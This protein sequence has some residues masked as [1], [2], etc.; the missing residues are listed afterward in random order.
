MKFGGHKVRTVTTL[1]FLGK[2]ESR[3]GVIY[4]DDGLNSDFLENGSNDF[5]NIGNLKVANNTLSS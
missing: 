4:A 3:S 5:A 2:M 1:N